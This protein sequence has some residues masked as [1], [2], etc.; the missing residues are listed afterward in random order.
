MTQYYY[1]D[2]FNVPTGPVTLD[3]L[4]QL[5][6]AGGVSD[7]TLVIEEGAAAW[8][9]LGEFGGSAAGSHREPVP[10][11]SQ[12]AR[13]DVIRERIAAGTARAGAFAGATAGVVGASMAQTFRSARTLGEKTVLA[14]S[15]LGLVAFVMPWFSAFGE[16]ASGLGIARQA[17]VL[18]LLPLS[19]VVCLFL[20]YMNVG[21]TRRRRTLRARW[22]ILIGGV[23]STA[24]IMGIFVGRQLFG[25][26]AF[27]LYATFV[28]V[29]G[30]VVG[31]FLQIRD[32]AAALPE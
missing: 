6:S 26:A 23:W 27:G 21:A 22:F 9:R 31:G 14:A 1:A 19:L 11:I 10:S 20:S 5:R 30:L 12:R 2:N 7:D 3:E 15:L 18:W 32:H 29:A 17:T 4:W 16:A 25:I 28:F 8:R 13:E 24:S